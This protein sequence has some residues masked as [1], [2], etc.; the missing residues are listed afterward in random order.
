MPDPNLT[1]SAWRKST[2]SQPDSQ[3]VEV[4]F[5]SGMTGVRD[6]KDRSYGTLEI[7]GDTWTAFLSNVKAGK[8]DL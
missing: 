1:Y 8:L 3:C 6:T 5:A 2:R 4:G 7:T